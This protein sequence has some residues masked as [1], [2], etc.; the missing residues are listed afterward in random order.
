VFCRFYRDFYLWDEL[1]RVIYGLTGIGGDKESLQKIA[2]DISTLV[3]RFNL[4]EG[5]KPEDERLP[6]RFHQKLEKTGQV[7]TEEEL[8]TMLKDYFIL[9]GWDE[10]GVVG[11]LLPEDVVIRER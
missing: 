9:R 1:T 10:N 7:I 8:E 5:M 2:G 3:R 11:E 6:K 4:R